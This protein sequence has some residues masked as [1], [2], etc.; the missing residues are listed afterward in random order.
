MNVKRAGTIKF[1]ENWEL[2]LKDTY[3]NI[4]DKRVI[5][6]TITNVWKSN[7]QDW[8]YDDSGS[9]PVVLAIGT[10][11]TGATSGDTVLETEFQRETAVI[12]KPA[13]YQVK[14]SKDFTFISGV[15]ENITEAGLFDSAV[16]SGSE[17]TARTTFS[18]IS[19]NEATTLTVE[20]TITIAGS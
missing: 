7:V 13:S 19:I 2:I 5:K 1:I 16:V 11:S 6:N 17:M 14:Y 12:S 10:G 8:M 20:A 3:G 9:R 4:I 15:S 18:S